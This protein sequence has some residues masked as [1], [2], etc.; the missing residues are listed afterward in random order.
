M[1]E[2]KEIL[3]KRLKHTEGLRAF[4]HDG[5][6]FLAHH[7]PKKIDNYVVSNLP[8]LL[9]LSFPVKR[10]RTGISKEMLHH[11]QFLN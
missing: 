10:G 5:K 1:T 2:L 7:T 9:N 6:I 11:L 4:E 8:G 3:F